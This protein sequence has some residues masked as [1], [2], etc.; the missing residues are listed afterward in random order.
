MSSGAPLPPCIQRCRNPFEDLEGVWCYTTDPENEYDPGHCSVPTSTIYQP[1]LNINADQD[2]WFES[3]AESTSWPAAEMPSSW[4]ICS[5]FKLI[6]WPSPKDTGISVW[7]LYALE[8]NALGEKNRSRESEGA[9]LISA[10]ESGTT[11]TARFEHKNFK[12]KKNQF[13]Q[14]SVRITTEKALF[15][16]RW[17]KSCFSVQ[18]ME[19]QRTQLRL[20]VDGSIIKEENFT[21]VEHTTV[22][23]SLVVGQM[24]DP[25]DDPI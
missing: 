21:D 22:D 15:P 14:H 10:T 12:L 18:Q 20:V 7:K 25:E 9:L 5:A 24:V 4:T 19:N 17:T 2:D 6:D 16:G 8:T 11:Y 1:I 23:S 3:F 13:G